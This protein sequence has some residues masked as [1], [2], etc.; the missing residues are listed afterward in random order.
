MYEFWYILY[1]IRHVSKMYR[2]DTYNKN[3]VKIRKEEFINFISCNREI[4]MKVSV[5]EPD[6]HLT[7]IFNYEIKY[8]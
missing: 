2:I 4:G 1:E 6:S 7:S 3:L 5:D 8:N